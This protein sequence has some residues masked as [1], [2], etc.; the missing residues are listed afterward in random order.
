MNN[1]VIV[2]GDIPIFRKFEI[3]SFS[4]KQTQNDLRSTPAITN[5]SAG[6]QKIPNGVIFLSLD[7]YLI[8]DI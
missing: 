6:K 5:Q 3:E 2:V 1:E 7:N 4:S 8:G